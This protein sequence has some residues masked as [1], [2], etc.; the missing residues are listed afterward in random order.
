MKEIS[1]HKRAFL[2]PLFKIASD[3]GR[4]VDY[5]RNFPHAPGVKACVRDTG[6]YINVWS[7]LFDAKD[8]LPD[9]RVSEVGYPKLK[10]FKILSR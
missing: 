2:D 4:T 6:R 1:N 10:N 3:E 8:A 9:I 7:H 5:L